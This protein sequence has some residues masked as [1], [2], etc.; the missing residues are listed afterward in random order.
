MFIF[1][2][3]AAGGGLYKLLSIVV[4]IFTLLAN[5]T[6]NG[7]I[8]FLVVSGQLIDLIAHLTAPH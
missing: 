5:K 4:V 6:L 8:D 2:N 1:G 7:K 3:G